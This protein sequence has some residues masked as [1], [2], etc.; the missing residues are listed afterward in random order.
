MNDALVEV[1]SVFPA[2]TAYAVPAVAPV[3][4]P[5]A[6]TEGPEGVKVYVKLAL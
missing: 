4:T 2:V 3:I 1:Q 6:P 5:P